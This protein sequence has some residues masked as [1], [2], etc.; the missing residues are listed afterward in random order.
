MNRPSD[1][2]ARLSAWLEEGPT[3]GPE[4]VL[5]RTF[6]RARSTRQDR[7]RLD[8]LTSPLR[9]QPMYTTLKITA[10][11]VLAMSAVIVI[12]P[13]RQPTPYG[14]VDPSPSPSAS[15][16]DL[17]SL[18]L[19]AALDAGVTY[20]LDW[21]R[22]HDVPRIEFT[23]PAD[24]WFQSGRGNVGKHD[25][26][27]L[28]TV[29]SVRNL[30]A[31]PCR[32]TSMG[33][34]DPPVGPSVEDLVSGLVAQAD[35]NASDPT[36]VTVGDHPAKRLELSL[37]ADLKTATC[38]GA[39][40]ARWFEHNYVGDDYVGGHMLGAGQRNIVHVIDVDGTRTLID[41][42]YLPGATDADL[43][44]AEQIIASMR[45]GP[46]ATPAPGSSPAT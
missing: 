34:L 46:L 37:P 45:F 16:I 33:E 38:E 25:R 20:V 11:A 39:Y 26:N 19:N 3:S 44:E 22:T 5:S 29:W 30:V 42:V 41:T 14:A 43:A 18:P 13:F 9:F 6:A 35:G 32:K 21:T 40:F 7:G 27:P 31:D 24:G 12:D 15:P 23:V 17:L 8:R 2:D 4:G 28:M 1:I 36:D 10:V